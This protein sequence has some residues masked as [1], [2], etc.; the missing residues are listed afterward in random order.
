[1]KIVAFEVEAWEREILDQLK[2]EHEIRYVEAALSAEN[3]SEYTDAEVIS[4]FIYSEL[5][6]E[7][8]N[9]FSHLKLITTRSTGFDQIDLSYCQQHNIV[10]C[11][12]PNYGE[13]TVAEH[14]FALLLALS[15]K[16]VDAVERTR[17]RDF[18]FKGLQGFDLRGKTLGVIGTGSIGR[19]VI[20]IAKG[21]RMEVVA[22]E[23]SPKED[24]A[25]K[26]GFRYAEL[27]ELLATAD[28][29]TLHVPANE[30]TRNFLS[31]T[32]FAQMKDGVILL[33]TTRGSVIDVLAL[34]QALADGKVAAAGLDVLP[35]EFVMR[36]ESELLKSVVNKEY[37]DLET[38]LANQVLLRLSNVIVTPHN[39]FNTRE[40]R[41]RILSTTIANINAFCQGNPQNLVNDK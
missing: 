4:I 6:T 7:I 25:A 22:Y 36:D 8:I 26:L 28:I 2:S 15:H 38:L 9:Q 34:L 18:S 19:C 13:H 40:A 30:K 3:V 11:N 33:N 39:A 23:S 32:E 17:E 27:P 21:F 35:D 29:I 16:I 24:L 5:S 10:V 12:V 14:V 1:M 20:E 37:D 31:T 41:E